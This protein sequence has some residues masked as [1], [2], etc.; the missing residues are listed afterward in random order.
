MWI[1]LRQIA[2]VATELEPVVS[3]FHH[4]LGLDVAYRDPGVAT[5]GLH[6]AVM[7]AGEQ[8]IEVVSPTGEGTAGGRY[9]D[10]RG[11]DGGYMVIMQCSDHAPVKARVEAAGVRK[12]VEHDGEHYQIMQLHPR[13]T[14][15]SFMEIDVQA[16]GESMDGPWEPAGPQWQVARTD[17]VQAIVTADIQADDPQRLGQ[18]WSEILGIQLDL[19]AG[20]PTIGLDNAALSFV[21]VTDGRGEGLR[22][23]GVRVSD[24]AAVVEAATARGCRVEEGRV[25]LGGLWVTPV[26]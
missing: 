4:V 23:I 8:F 24:A 15:G 12:V 18:R 11:G 22:G 19:I 20:V 1:R 17:V 6:N 7:P 10:R 26:H 14:G 3:D 2:L 5:F 13:D 9:L 25:L 21:P 16:G